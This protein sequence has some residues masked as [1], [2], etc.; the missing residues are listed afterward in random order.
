MLKQSVNG[1]IMC[2]HVWWAHSLLWFGEP[3]QG[4]LQG[5]KTNLFSI[6]VKKT[7]Q[8]GLV[9]GYVWLW[10]SLNV[11]PHV[12]ESILVRMNGGIIQWCMPWN[13]HPGWRCR[14]SPAVLFFLL[15][16]LLSS[17]CWISGQQS[18]K[19]SGPYYCAVLGLL[20][21]QSEDTQFYPE[22]ILQQHAGECPC[23]YLHD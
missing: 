17:K 1:C 8:N 5:C 12:M 16:T 15:H 19:E 22:T 3:F 14:Q 21:S 2:R 23:L 6:F 18:G 13:H 11:L 10:V 9:G 20:H 7:I 4:L